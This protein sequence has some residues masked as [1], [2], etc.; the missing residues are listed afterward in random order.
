[1]KQLA[2]LM[3]PSHLSWKIIS[4]LVDWIFIVNHLNSTGYDISTLVGSLISLSP[5]D[6]NL[7]IVY[8]KQSVYYE[9]PTGS[10]WDARWAVGSGGEWNDMIHMSRLQLSYWLVCTSWYQRWH[11]QQC[12]VD[13][14]RTRIYWLLSETLTL[15]N[16]RIQR[17]GEGGAWREGRE[18]IIEVRDPVHEKEGPTPRNG[19]KWEGTM[20][21]MDSWRWSPP[22]IGEERERKEK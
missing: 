1:M 5:N 11:P 7:F 16:D 22:F 21:L 9:T 10:R 18:G 15:R 17:E 8:L 14:K 12:Q 20:G 2:F 3:N 19:D 6:S 13:P 4:W